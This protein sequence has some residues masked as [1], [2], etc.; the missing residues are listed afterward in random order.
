MAINRGG[1]GA[2]FSAL[3]LLSTCRTIQLK[4]KEDSI[5]WKMAT[6]SGPDTDPE[7]VERMESEGKGR[8][9]ILHLCLE[10]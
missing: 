4:N 8:I 2:L 5:V 1:G 6:S 7:D 9:F 10:I 3:L